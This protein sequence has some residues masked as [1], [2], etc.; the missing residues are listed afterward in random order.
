MILVLPPQENLYSPPTGDPDNE[1]TFGNLHSPSNLL[2]SL[3][4]LQADIIKR[5]TMTILQKIPRDV[6][7]EIVSHAH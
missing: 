4:A 3:P 5:V 6:Y 1:L 7:T 2:R